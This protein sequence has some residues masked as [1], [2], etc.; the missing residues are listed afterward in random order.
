ML[1]TTIILFALAAV[2]GAVLLTKVFKDEERP[3]A[4][5]YSRGDCLGFINYSLYKSRWQLVV[6]DEHTWICGGSFG[7]FCDVWP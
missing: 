4:V 6:N 7:W 2:L 1:I 3:K 5:I